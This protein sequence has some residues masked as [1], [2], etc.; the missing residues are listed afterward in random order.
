MNFQFAPLSLLKYH[1]EHSRFEDRDY[2]MGMAKRLVDLLKSFKVN[3]TITNIDMSPYAACFDMV[4]DPGVS[5]KAIKGLRVEIEVH[6]GFPVEIVSIGETEFT[7]KLAIKNLDRPLLGLRE[8]L[9]SDEF[10][11]ND[12]EIPIA[13][14]GDVLGRPFVFDMADTPH[15]LVAGATGS[16]K[17]IFL[18]DMILSILYSRRP[19]EVQ[20]ILV[21]PKIVEFKP[22]DGIPHLLMP[23]VLSSENAYNILGWAEDETMRRYNKFSECGVKT[24]DAYN[25]LSSGQEKLP[26]IVIIIDEYME[27]MEQMKKELE[28]IIKRIAQLSRGAGIHLVLCTQRPTAN[29]V[30]PDIKANLPCRASFTMVDSRESKEISER[31]GTERLLGSGD[32]L[33]SKS[34]ASRTVHAQTA[35][36][37]Y[38]EI[39]AV[40]DWYRN[41]YRL[42]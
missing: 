4:P 10:R 2:V 27:M 13:V 18:H 1:N 20:L 25:T 17:S 42:R 21:D 16:G 14:G 36:V 35:Y 39:D 6:M 7:L 29:V 15:L 37:S 34:A 31:T 12:Y 9:E 33:F 41:K 23:P 32:L 30:T 19:D 40:C 5:V 24:L 3:V 22:Y 38:P 28:E 26:R 8:I 11:N